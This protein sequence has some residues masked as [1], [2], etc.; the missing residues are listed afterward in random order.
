MDVV[1]AEDAAGQ[2]EPTHVLEILLEEQARARSIVAGLS[3]VPVRLSRATTEFGA[4]LVDKRTRS[5][6]I[7]IS[8]YIEDDATVRETARH[9]FAHQA[10]WERYGHLGHGPLWQ[11]MA[12]YLGCAPVACTTYPVNAGLL[13][14]RQ[15]Y[16][17]T[18]ESCGWATMRQRRS[19][20]V[21]RPWRYACARCNG[22]L[23]V[24]LLAPA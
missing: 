4:F 11:T 20:L 1:R 23:R 8:R 9:E 7:R 10:A 3:H 19:K 12:V 5:M 6:E 18:C 22:A 13:S 24:S 17:V 16:A 14:E 21:A 15:R 2:M